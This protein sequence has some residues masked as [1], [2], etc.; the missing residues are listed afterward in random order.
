MMNPSEKKGPLV[1]DKGIFQG[2]V[3]V[4]VEELR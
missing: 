3:P 2:D 1:S 4:D